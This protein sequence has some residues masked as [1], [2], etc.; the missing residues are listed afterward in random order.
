MQD[1]LKMHNFFT[2]KLGKIPISRKILC[3]VKKSWELCFFHEKS[4]MRQ[5]IVYSV[6]AF[7]YT[8]SIGWKM[9]GNLPLFL[10]TQKI[11]I[12][13][14]IDERMLHLLIPEN[15]QLAQ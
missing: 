8:I 12:A 13:G 11:A 2:G 6:W 4:A 5:A 10:R 1:S 15:W 14:E 3:L 7:V 9:F